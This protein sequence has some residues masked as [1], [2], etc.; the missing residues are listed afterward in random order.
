MLQELVK[1]LEVV[2]EVVGDTDGNTYN[3]KD[4]IQQVLAFELTHNAH[5][6]LLMKYL[7][8]ITYLQ[9]FVQQEG[10]IT[11]KG[12]MF[13]LQ[14]KNYTVGVIINRSGN[15]I[16]YVNEGHNQTFDV[17]YSFNLWDVN[18]QVIS[19]KDEEFE[20]FEPH[21]LVSNLLLSNADPRYSDIDSML[22]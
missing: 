18:E 15:E 8:K 14:N 5:K 2:K 21:L 20:T 12:W 10:K 1:E 19:Y 22:S 9:P 11:T 6:E 13:T 7:H 16:L 17:S 4:Y 3:N